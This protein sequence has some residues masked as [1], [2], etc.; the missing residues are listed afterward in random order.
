MWHVVGLEKG[1]VKV[2]DA[3]TVVKDVCMLFT[4]EVKC[5]ETEDLEVRKI[6]YFYFVTYVKCTPDLAVL[7]LNAVVKGC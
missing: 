4:D 5:M 1:C 3:M 7:A 2:I 6:M